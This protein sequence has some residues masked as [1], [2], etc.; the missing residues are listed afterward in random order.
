MIDRMKSIDEVFMRLRA[1][2]NMNWLYFKLFIL[3]RVYDVEN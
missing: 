1:R 2:Q 3:E